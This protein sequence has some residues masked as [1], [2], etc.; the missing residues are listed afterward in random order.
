[1]GL[2]FKLEF[3]SVWVVCLYDAKYVKQV[4][5]NSG[6]IIRNILFIL[7]LKASMKKR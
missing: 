2:T 3:L 4:V 1:M 7:T 6:E 5:L